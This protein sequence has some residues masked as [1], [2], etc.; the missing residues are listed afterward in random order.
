MS[1]ARSVLLREPFRRSVD[2][3]A[4]RPIIPSLP[5]KEGHCVN[6]PMLT[7]ART[8]ILRLGCGAP[9]RE[10]LDARTE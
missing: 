6:A 8:Q 5:A 4:A 1:T 9:R 2:V 3:A 7:P 10:V